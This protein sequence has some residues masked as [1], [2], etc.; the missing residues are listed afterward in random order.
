MSAKPI[1]DVAIAAIPYWEGLAEGRLRFQQ[2]RHCG[3]KWM[4]AS[5]ACPRC[6]S[7]DA[8]WIDASGRG[9]VVSWIVYHAAYDPSFADRVPYDVTIVE[10]D[11]GPRVITNIVNGDGGKAIRWK[12]RVRLA[13]G[14][15]DGQPIARFALEKE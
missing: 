11:E 14:E 2:C 3:N 10:L 1:T 8:E 15:Q 13:I 5:E 4:P 6:L 9:H 7:T 12:A